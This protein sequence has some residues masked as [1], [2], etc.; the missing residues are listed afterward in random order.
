MIIFVIVPIY[1]AIIGVFFLPP[2]IFAL[3]SGRLT[4]SIARSLGP[5]EGVGRG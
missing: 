1:A 5:R 2:L 3:L 4:G